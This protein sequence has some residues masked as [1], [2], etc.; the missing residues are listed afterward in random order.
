MSAVGLFWQKVTPTQLKRIVAAVAL[1]IVLLLAVTVAGQVK[2]EADG[3]ASSSASG[4]A[5]Q[6]P[7]SIFGARSPGRRDDGLVLWAKKRLKG[8]ARTQAPPPRRERVLPVTRTRQPLALPAFTPEG[9]LSLLG[10]PSAINPPV[11]G[12]SSFAPPIPAFT[13]P[14]FDGL[15]DLPPSPGG[16]GGNDGTNPLPPGPVVPELA[17]WLQ[18]VL[19]I[20]ALGLALRRSAES[21]GPIDYANSH[22]AD[23]LD[24]AGCDRSFQP[25]T[26]QSHCAS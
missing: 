12:P 6:S 3:G 23:E 17:T 15:L 7:A 24:R 25:L 2:V 5:W 11:I 1:L 26:C 14:G 21:R 19:A 20:G 16:V 22:T 8:L 13:A 10:T 18:M 9:P 4:G